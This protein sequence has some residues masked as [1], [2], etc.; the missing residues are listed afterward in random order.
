MER[1]DTN[2]RNAD[3]AGPHIGFPLNFLLVDTNYM[4]FYF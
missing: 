4:G 1:L 2:M 3:L